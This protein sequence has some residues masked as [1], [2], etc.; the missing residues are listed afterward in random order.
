[1]AGSFQLFK[2]NS[3]PLVS[4]LVRQLPIGAI[5]LDGMLSSDIATLPS[6]QSSLS[7][8]GCYLAGLSHLHFWWM[9]IKELFPCK[10]LRFCAHCQTAPLLKPLPRWILLQ[11]SYAVGFWPVTLCLLF[12]ERKF[13]CVSAGFLSTLFLKAIR[14]LNDDITDH[15]HK[16]VSLFGKDKVDFCSTS[17]SSN[18][19][20]IS[21]WLPASGCLAGD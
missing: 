10:W 15:H 16:R 11:A 5:M 19:L 12:Q 18:A 14:K 21:F 1:M 13:Y 17:S 4:I 6:R 20:N 3:L 8:T 7:R 9:A 2:D